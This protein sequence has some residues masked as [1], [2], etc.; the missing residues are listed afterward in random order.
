M[1]EL[2]PKC[3]LNRQV[4]TRPGLIQVFARYEDQRQWIIEE[5]L[6][7]MGRAADTNNSVTRFQYMTH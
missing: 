5:I 4:S 7:S 6:T 1:L 2:P 3:E